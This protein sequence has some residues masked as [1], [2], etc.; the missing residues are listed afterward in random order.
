MAEQYEAMSYRELQAAA[1]ALGV[2]ASGKRDELLARL[3]E[4]QQANAG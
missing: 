1:K 3:L 2:K 4:E